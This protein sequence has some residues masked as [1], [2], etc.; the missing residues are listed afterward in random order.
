MSSR[1]CI[2]CSR[3]LPRSSYTANQYSRGEGDSCCAACVH[4]HRNDTPTAIQSDSGR[5]NRA[6]EAKF[7]QNSMANPFVQG[8]FR[9]V[10]KGAYV[11]GGRQGQACVC[12]WFKAGGTMDSDYF[13]LDI[14]S[15]D[16]ALEIINH[17]NQLNILNKTVKVNVPE[18]WVWGGNN[19]RAGQKSLVEPFIQNYKKFNSNSGWTDESKPWALAMQALSHFSYHISG[20]NFVLCDLQ[21][22]I[23]QNEVVL[24]DPVILS[25][26]QQ[27]GVTDLGPNGIS[28]F[29]S[30]HVCNEHSVN[31]ALEIWRGQ[32]V[33][34]EPF[35]ENHQMFN[36][37]LGWVTDDR[38]PWPLAMQAL[39]HFRY[40]ITGGQYVLCDL[41]GGV[42]SHE[43]ILTDPAIPSHKKEFGMTDLGSDGISNFF[44]K[45]VCNG[46]CR[47]D[48]PGQRNQCGTLIQFPDRRR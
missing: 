9:W 47:R 31:K 43:V 42:Y 8:A 28:S 13:T 17:F 16:K 41:Q 30:Q 35:I 3:S 15:V 24:T 21:G 20:G 39:S 1:A 23:Y 46:F 33:L 4:S 44:R 34:V 27:Y 38:R 2:S 10:A 11:D 36:S 40:H 45:H 18:V 26:T 29:F 19:S 6:N 12:K 5:Y 14:K 37:N 32:T 48:W 22:G 25:P 7:T